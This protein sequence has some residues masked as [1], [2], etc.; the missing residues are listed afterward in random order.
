MLIARLIVIA[1]IKKA[2]QLK[3]LGLIKQ[4]NRYLQ[5]IKRFTIVS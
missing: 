2:Q 5:L 4:S 3:L 1:K